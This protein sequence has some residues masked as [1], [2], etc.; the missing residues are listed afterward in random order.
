MPVLKRI[1]HLV[2][3]SFLGEALKGV[4]LDQNNLKDFFVSH[5]KNI[6]EQIINIWKT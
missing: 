2:D 1:K 6:K 3:N 4:N 5:N